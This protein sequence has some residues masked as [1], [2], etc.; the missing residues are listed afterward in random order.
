LVLM[1]MASL[2]QA[3]AQPI[4]SIYVNLYTDSLKK[5][6]YN[7]I[8]VIGL[9]ANGRYRPLD[10]T[11]LRFEASAGR[12]VGN[13]LWLDKD[14]AGEKVHIKV[15]LRNNP[16]V[17][18]AFDIYIKTKADDQP[19]KTADEVLAEMQQAQQAGKKRR[20]RKQ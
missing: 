11:H 9:L 2:A 19:L 14:F 8:N 18:K 12:F 13:S 1:T 16:A 6:T 17:Q 5:S 4:D 10:S 3:Q 20:N 7:Y 15:T